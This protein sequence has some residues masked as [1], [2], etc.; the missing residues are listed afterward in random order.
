M[1]Y[2]GEDISKKGLGIKME[3]SCTIKGIR[4]DADDAKKISEKYHWFLNAQR[5][6][7]VLELDAIIL[8]YKIAERLYDGGWSFKEDLWEAICSFEDEDAELFNKLKE[9][10]NNALQKGRI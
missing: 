5:V 9:K 4:L 6:N 3:F 8:S 2:T 7:T 10:F 1:I